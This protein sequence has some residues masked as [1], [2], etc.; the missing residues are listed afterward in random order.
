MGGTPDEVLDDPGLWSM[1]API[2]RADLGMA[3]NWPPPLLMQGWE[4]HTE[5]F[6]S[7]RIFDGGHFYFA[8][9]PGPLLRQ[10]TRD[11]TTARAAADATRSG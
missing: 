4:E 8:E 10:I 2:I 7:L 11:A 3:E 1:C 9:D 6:L 5:H